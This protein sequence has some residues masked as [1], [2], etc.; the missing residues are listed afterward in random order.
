M[1]WSNEIYNGGIHALDPRINT[2]YTYKSMTV[3]PPSNH[4]LI[5]CWVIK[6]D[7]GSSMDNPN[8]SSTTSLK[9]CRLEK[10]PKSENPRL[11]WSGNEMESTI[12]LDH[13]HV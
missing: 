11:M 9:K 13:S 12:N 5:N 7:L 10:I 4:G 6:I 8:A 2:K 1:I 3:W